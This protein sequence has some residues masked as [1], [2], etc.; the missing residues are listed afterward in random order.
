MDK[1][2]TANLAY[3]RSHVNGKSKIASQLPYK[4]TESQFISAPAPFC[5][6]GR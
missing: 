4:V 3:P 1:S 5:V 6:T 2:L